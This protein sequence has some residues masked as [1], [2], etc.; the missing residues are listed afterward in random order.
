MFLVCSDGSIYSL[1]LTR[2]SLDLKCL[3]VCLSF[4]RSHNFIVFSKDSKDI[5]HFLF[6]NQK[7]PFICFQG[8]FL[9]LFNLMFSVEC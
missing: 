3:T 2:R 7:E 6:K 9:L 8:E 1:G 4:I 5:K